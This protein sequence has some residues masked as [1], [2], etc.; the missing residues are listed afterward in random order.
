MPSKE[1]CDS[2]LDKENDQLDEA[3]D[4][5]DDYNEALDEM[6][7]AAEAAMAGAVKAGG[8]GLGGDWSDAFG[9]GV[10]AA[11]GKRAFERASEKVERAKEKYEREEAKRD[12]LMKQWCEECGE[13]PD[14]EL[15][16]LTDPCGEHSVEFDESEVPPI[17][18]HPG[19]KGW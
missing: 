1:Y 9:S 12:K 18:G 19:G 13:P 4:A 5:L 6:E 14:P 10:D 17:M 16:D 7:A 2:L 15:D 11:Q 8:Y 3:Q